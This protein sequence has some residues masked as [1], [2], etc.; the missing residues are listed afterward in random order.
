MGEHSPGVF[1]QSP[2]I[3]IVT[4]EKEKQE[5]LKKGLEAKKLVLNLLLVP[6]IHF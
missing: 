3:V 6:H 5:G 4:G 1:C 2:H